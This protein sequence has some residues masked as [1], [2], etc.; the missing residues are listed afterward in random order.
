VLLAAAGAGVAALLAPAL[1]LRA[2][3]ALAPLL[4][5]AA[6]GVLGATVAIA[7]AAVGWPALVSL[8]VVCLLAG[9]WR[10]RG[11]PAPAT[12]G[13]GATADRA[14]AGAGVLAAVALLALAGRTFAVAPLDGY[15]AWAMWTMKGRALFELGW[16]E[17]AVFAGDAYSLLHLDYPLLLP[18]LEAIAFHAVGAFDARLVHVELLLFAPALLTALWSLLR[19]LVAPRLL[20]PCLLA[21]LA[22]PALLGQLLT[23]YADVPLACFFAAGFAALARWLL[24]EERW[25]LAVATLC[26]AAAV[27]TKN[28]GTLYAA[29]A[30]AAAAL[31]LVR[32]PRRRLLALAASAGLVALAAAPWR[33]YTA[34]YGLGNPDARLL[35]SFDLPYVAGRLGRGPLAARALAE[36]LLDPAVWGLLVPLAVGAAVM[37]W[38]A[39]R[40]TVPAAL[41]ALAAIVLAVLTW[42]YVISPLPIGDYL[43]G[44]TDR[45]IA[46]LVLAGAA[47][48]P[49]MAAAPAGQAPPCGSVSRGG[50][51]SGGCSNA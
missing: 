37:S 26:F 10:L 20:W 38:L 36:S 18:S 13:R 32:R 23:G 11:R 51:R 44:T 41:G 39:G 5:L 40:R 24:T 29:A 47:A 15:D 35:D 34:V 12:T 49:L 21:I 16:A 27:L 17:P 43:A 48:A 42:A 46:S 1:P 14:A 30:Y 8:A 4:G 50:A 6:G 22:A 19:D 2:L 33:A 7:R 3:L 25:P 45:V 31:V 9:A 28:E